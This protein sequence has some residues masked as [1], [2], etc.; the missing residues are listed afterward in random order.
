[1]HN[2]SS[3][4][5][6]TICCCDRILHHL[7]QSNKASVSSLHCQQFPCQQISLSANFLVSNCQ[8]S[9]VSKLHC[10]QYPCQQISLSAIVSKTLSASSIVSNFLVSK[11]PCQQ[12]SA[13]HC[14]QSLQHQQH[15]AGAVVQ[16]KLT[17]A[18][19]T[20]VYVC[21]TSK[22]YCSNNQRHSAAHCI[23]ESACNP[24][25]HTTCCRAALQRHAACHCHKRT[26]PCN[27]A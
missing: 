23:L 8:Q 12:L 4:I 6:V 9:I 19:H 15:K 10:Q 22:M 21:M 18:L 2:G 11:F 1:M 26:L 14:Q 17:A 5:S 7:L 25:A 3:L 27:L 16:S 20:S 13:N 24:D